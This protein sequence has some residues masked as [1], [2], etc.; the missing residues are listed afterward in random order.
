VIGK[1]DVLW[2]GSAVIVARTTELAEQLLTG[3]DLRCPRCGD[4]QLTA[5]GYG[6]RRTIRSHG[7]A[8]VTI[9][10]RRTRCVSCLSTHVVMPAALQP[11]H[12]DTTAVIGTALLHKANGLGHR[13]IAVAI[14]RPVSTVR[15]WL[16]RLPP[17]HLDRIHRDGVQRLLRLDPD[18]FTA[19]RYDGN[20]L[21]HALSVLS[22]ATYWDR[23]RCGILDPPWTLIGMYTRGR[24]LAP[25]D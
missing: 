13:R 10:P 1:A 23:H 16:R 14:D 9:R 4:G 21:R 25:P 11:R 19:L 6:R 22:A 20:M 24:L 3:G 18:T 12:A 5:W 7:T 17:A 8:T 2:T 15:R